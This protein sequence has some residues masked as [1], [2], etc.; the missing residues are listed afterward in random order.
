[1]LP[2]PQEEK[3]ADSVLSGLAGGP[4]RLVSCSGRWGVPGSPAA[5]GWQ[6]LGK[7][8]PCFSPRPGPRAAKDSRSELPGGLDVGFC[9]RRCTL[10]TRWGSGSGWTARTARHSWTT[11]RRRST[12]GCPP[13]ACSCRGRQGAAEGTSVLV[14]AVGLAGRERGFQRKAGAGVTPAREPG[15]RGA[16]AHGTGGCTSHEAPI[17]REQPTP[18]PH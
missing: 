6:R 11:S 1:M 2:G 10:R 7:H 9:A 3:E 14:R 8:L 12:P 13:G 18:L 5:G 4:G 16:G 15:I 17:C